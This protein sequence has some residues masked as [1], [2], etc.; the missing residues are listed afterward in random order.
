MKTNEILG[1]DIG[2]SGIKGAV[3]NT[4]TGELCSAR[5][6]LPTPSDGKPKAIAKVLNELVKQIGWKKTIG[7]GFPAIIKNGV[8]HS[9]SNI[10]KSW[11]GEDAAALFSRTTGC[12]TFVV[13]D[14]DAAGMAEIKLGAAKQ[15]NGVVMLIT[16][17]SGLGSATFI[18]GKLVPNTE[19]GHLRFKKGIAEAYASDSTRKREDLSWDTWGKRFNEYLLHLDRLFSPDLY[20]LGG[21][22]S[23][24][25]EKFSHQLTTPNK[26]VPA[27][28]QNNAGIIG[29]A[30]HGLSKVVLK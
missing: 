22:G 27:L 9:A 18:N 8:A 3:V 1:I 14:A 23:K 24:K 20:V 12:E 2:A 25:F 10:D 4:T 29:A 28:F 6:R 5:L 21:G 30:M 17:G 7:C 26:V 11:I 19:L 13:N 15:Y 16:I